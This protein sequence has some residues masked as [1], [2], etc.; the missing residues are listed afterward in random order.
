MLLEALE[1]LGHYCP[2]C[3]APGVA[4]PVPPAPMRTGTTSKYQRTMHGPALSLWPP[5]DPVVAR[6]ALCR[7]EATGWKLRRLYQ[8]SVAH[9]LAGRAS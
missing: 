5:S 8:E 6:C 9:A 3:Q 2:S 4:T 7:F 1:L